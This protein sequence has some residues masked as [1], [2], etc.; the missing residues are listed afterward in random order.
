LYRF[1]SSDAGTFDA[2][3]AVAASTSPAWP[4]GSARDC[5]A[6]YPAGG[7]PGRLLHWLLQPRRFLLLA[8]TLLTLIRLAG[9]TGLL[10]SISHATL[11]N[12]PFWINWV[13]QQRGERLHLAPPRH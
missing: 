8:G 10:G 13:A 3:R 11:F 7:V 4:S 5:G 6:L 9:V 12:P 2:I 1:A